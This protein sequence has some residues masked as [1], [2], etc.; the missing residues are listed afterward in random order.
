MLNTNATPDH[1]R[2]TSH[3]ESP[4]NQ[5]GNAVAQFNREKENTQMETTEMTD[6]DQKPLRDFIQ[7]DGWAVM[8][9]LVD[10]MMVPDDDGDVLMI[11]RQWE[12][13]RSGTTVRIHIDATAE[14]DDVLRII[15]KQLAWFEECGASQ[16]ADAAQ[17]GDR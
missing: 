6:A 12:P 5:L 11:C 3:N 10:Y 1:Y 4:N 8:G 2:R 15:R 14:R 13:Q 7:I 17:A 9:H 16:L